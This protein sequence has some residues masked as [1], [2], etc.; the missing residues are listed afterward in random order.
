MVHVKRT[1]REMVIKLCPSSMGLFAVLLLLYGVPEI[2][3]LK[4]YC[5]LKECDFIRPSDCPG[6]GIIIKDPCK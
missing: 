1:F 3:S 5:E 4:C 2:T 6:K